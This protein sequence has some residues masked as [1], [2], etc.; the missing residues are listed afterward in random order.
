MILLKVLR[1]KFFIKGKTSGWV[2]FAKKDVIAASTLIG[3]AELTGEVALHCQQAIEKYFKAYLTE[4]DK[5][6][7][8]II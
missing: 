3:N 6:V 2:F 1:K 7:R 8:K 5:Q 4:N